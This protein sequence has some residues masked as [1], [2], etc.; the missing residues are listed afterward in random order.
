MGLPGA[1][2]IHSVMCKLN[3][4]LKLHGMIPWL[5]SKVQGRCGAALLHHAADGHLNRKFDK[6]TPLENLFQKIGHAKTYLQKWAM[7][8]FCAGILIMN[9]NGQKNPTIFI[10]IFFSSRK[11]NRNCRLENGNDIGNIG[12]S[13]TGRRNG[14]YRYW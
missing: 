10:F 6:L 14:I 3:D 11:Q 2:W 9:E 8:I 13:E 5:I 1:C 7:G 4:L 12:T